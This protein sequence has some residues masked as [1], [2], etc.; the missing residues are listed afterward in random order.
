MKINIDSWHY[1]VYRWGDDETKKTLNL[2]PYVRRVLLKL[3]LLLW[4]LAAEGVLFYWFFSKVVVPHFDFWL[5]IISFI[6]V[7]TPASLAGAEFL[8]YARR[9]RITPVERV[10]DKTAGVLIE[11]WQSF[12]KTS[13]AVVLWKYLKAAHDKIC[14][15][16]YYQHD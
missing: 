1:K 10:A 7:A 15:N 14:P 9:R 11:G 3:A 5:F 16:I 12:S 2:C 6:L 13:F 4:F 8:N